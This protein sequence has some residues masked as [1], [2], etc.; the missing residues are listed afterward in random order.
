[1]FRK[2]AGVSLLIV[3]SLGVAVA[4]EAHPAPTQSKPSR[5]TVG[6]TYST[7]RG[8][9]TYSSCT[10]FWLQGGAADV[11]WNVWRA[12]GIDAQVEG[13]HAGNI[14]PGVDLSKVTFLIGPRITWRPVTP[15]IRKHSAS[16]FGEFLMG[17]AQVFNTVIPTVPGVTSSASAFAVQTGFGSNLWLTH[18]FG[19]R[20]LE[21]D[22]EYS[23]IP[24]GGSGTQSEVRLA[25]GI[26]WRLP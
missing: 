23:Q 14:G 20:V 18:H 2:I 7:E 10:C 4:Q 8:K 21:I 12:V 5:V 1:M 26:V 25:S 19:V 6:V 9:T 17:D 15:R 3:A 11:N 22:Y 24:N 16:I 13:G